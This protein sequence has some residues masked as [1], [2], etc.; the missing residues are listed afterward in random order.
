MS[1][2]F[3]RKL[4]KYVEFE[5][6]LEDKIMEYFNFNT[7]QTSASVKWEAFKAD[8]RGEIISYT[9]HHTKVHQ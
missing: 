8:I 9:R 4:L 2:R 1:F 6:F 3:Q 5:K 7:D